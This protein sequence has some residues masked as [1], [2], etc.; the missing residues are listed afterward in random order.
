[1]DILTKRL[2][3]PAFFHVFIMQGVGKSEKD[4]RNPSYLHYTTKEGAWHRNV[5]GEE[6]MRWVA[7]MDGKS[8]LYLHTKNFSE[9]E[10][11]DTLYTK[12]IFGW[13]QGE[14]T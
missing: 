7:D 1:M 11:Y 3:K 13:R 14:T 5:K 10:K 2:L 12:L 8:S 9:I 6:S 4:W